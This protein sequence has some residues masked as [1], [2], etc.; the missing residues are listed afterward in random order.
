MLAHH[1]LEAFLDEYFA[2]PNSRMM[3]DPLF[4]T[5]RG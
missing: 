3:K 1:K 5:A 2:T 4:R